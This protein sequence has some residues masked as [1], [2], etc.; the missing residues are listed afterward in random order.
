MSFNPTFQNY[1]FIPLFQNN[2]NFNGANNYMGHMM[3]QQHM[4]TQPTHPYV[5][6]MNTMPYQFMGGQQPVSLVDST[7]TNQPNYPLLFNPSMMGKQPQ[8][9][10]VIASNPLQMSTASSMSPIDQRLRMSNPMMNPLMFTSQLQS[11]PIQQSSSNSESQKKLLDANA[12]KPP[13]LSLSSSSTGIPK[14][15]L[16]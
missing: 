6:H 15:D 16:T 11:F 9:V 10:P 3:G 1:N 8:L 4:I 2:M 7:V 12:K 14:R 13:L 5:G